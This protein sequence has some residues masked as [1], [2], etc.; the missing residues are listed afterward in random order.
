[1]APAHASRAP[2]D[3]GANDRYLRTRAPDGRP[4]PRPPFRVARTA[5][6]LTHLN[7]LELLPPLEL[8]I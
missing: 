6:G 8:S 1:M 2:G 5:D 3:P 7:T 4:E